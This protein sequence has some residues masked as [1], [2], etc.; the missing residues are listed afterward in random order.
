MD[1][2]DH[3]GENHV[4]KDSDFT[5]LLDYLQRQGE[6]DT[7]GLAWSQLDASLTITTNL[8]LDCIISSDRSSYSDDGLVYIRGNFFRFSL[9]PLMQ[10]MLQV[11][12][13]VA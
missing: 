5:L 10:L 13:E 9:N 2:H 3:I 4:D 11:S 1:G 8:F 12:L 7:V 6:Q